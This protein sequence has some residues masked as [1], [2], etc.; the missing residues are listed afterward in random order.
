MD[1][2]LSD[3][4]GRDYSLKQMV[5]ALVER[6]RELDN[7]QFLEVISSKQNADHESIIS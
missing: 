1:R 7:S 6:D 4:C 2:L 5:V 3:R